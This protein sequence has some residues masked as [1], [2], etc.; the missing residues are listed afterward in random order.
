MF[1]HKTPFLRCNMDKI[2][3]LSEVRSNLSGIISQLEKDRRRVI[4]T[5]HG[6]PAAVI[7]SPEELETLETSADTKLLSSLRRRFR[8]IH[9]YTRYGRHIGHIASTARNNAKGKRASRRSPH[10]T[11]QMQPMR[12]D[13]ERSNGA[14]GQASQMPGLRNNSIRATGIRICH[15]KRCR[16]RSSGT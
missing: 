16:I 12:E 7:I 14:H 1:D 9:F 4:V 5:V 2:A 10:D 6:K 13:S 8:S 11:L 3:P 15:S